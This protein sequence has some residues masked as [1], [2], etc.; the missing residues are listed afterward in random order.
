MTQSSNYDASSNQA[1]ASQTKHHRS[2]ERVT[3]E[4]AEPKPNYL[5]KFPSAIPI[6][7]K[8]REANR[9][10]IWFNAEHQTL[11]FIFPWKYLPAGRRPCWQ[12]LRINPVSP[13][14]SIV[15]LDFNIGDA[16]GRIG[17]VDVGAP[18]SLEWKRFWKLQ[19][20]KRKTHNRT[21]MCYLF[22]VRLYSV[23]TRSK[24]M[25]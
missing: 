13:R 7:I 15:Y 18:N 12:T 25:I 4:S 8:L 24:V 1:S 23:C 2:N 22:C 16:L 6:S 11:Y 19:F 10:F 21:I 17:S 9:R 5:Y 20:L 3:R 14:C